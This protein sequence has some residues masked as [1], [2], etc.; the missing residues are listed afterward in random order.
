MPGNASLQADG[1]DSNDE[2]LPENEYEVDGILGYHVYITEGPEWLIQWTGYDKAYNE[3]RSWKDVQGCR[4]LIKEF[5]KTHSVTLTTVN[6]HEVGAAYTQDT[7]KLIQNLFCHE[8]LTRLLDLLQS[9]HV[10]VT[11]PAVYYKRHAKMSFQGANN[12]MLDRIVQNS[13]HDVQ[14]SSESGTAKIVTQHIFAQLEEVCVSLPEAAGVL[15]LANSLECQQTFDLCRLLHIIY[16]WTLHL[17][18]KTA[19]TLLEEDITGSASIYQPLLNW[20]IKFVRDTMINKA[21]QRQRKGEFA[22]N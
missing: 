14:F 12:H 6:R 9:L 11:E 4:D 7:V 18:P 19:G 3:W 21:C 10:D 8:R 20:I 5:N 17:G 16:H 1:N 2:E 22:S 15:K 13:A